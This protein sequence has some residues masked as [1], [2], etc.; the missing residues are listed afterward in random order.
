MRIRLNHFSA[1]TPPTRGRA[2]SRHILGDD[3]PPWA[4]LPKYTLTREDAYRAAKLR[5]RPG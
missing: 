3:H 2:G 4:P 5:R 1:E